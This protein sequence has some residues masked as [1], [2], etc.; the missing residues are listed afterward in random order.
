MISQSELP[1]DLPQ[2]GF[3]PPDRGCARGFAGT[4]PLRAAEGSEAKDELAQNF[5]IER[6][7]GHRFHSLFVALKGL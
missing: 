5:L 2:R 7:I 4:A 3:V 6:E 1:P